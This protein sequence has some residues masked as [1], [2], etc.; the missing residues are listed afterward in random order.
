MEKRELEENELMHQ[1]RDIGP[2]YVWIYTLGNHI[3]VHKII[4]NVSQCKIW[5]TTFG[6]RGKGPIEIEQHHL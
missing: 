2:H 5:P 3:G 4:W 6:S 1:Y